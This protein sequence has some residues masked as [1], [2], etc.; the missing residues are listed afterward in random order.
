MFPRLFALSA[1]SLFVVGGA[2]LAP[3]AP[4]V[5]YVTNLTGSQETPANRALGT[6]TATLSIDGEMMHYT[7]TVQELSGTP[8]AAHVHSGAIGVGGPPVIT[9]AIKDG[10]GASGVVAEGDINLATALGGGMTADSLRSLLRQGHG[11]VNV[12]TALH[13]AGEIRGQLR[14]KR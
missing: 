8:T 2:L 11:Y 1:G 3:K 10:A 13:P 4:P 7:V 6:G 14:Q 5:I 9:F 12:H